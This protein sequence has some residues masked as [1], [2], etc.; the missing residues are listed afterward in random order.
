MLKSSFYITYAFLMTTGTITFIEALRTKDPHVRNILNLETCIS[1]VAAFFYG[2]FISELYES[3]DSEKK[4]LTTE[5]H[6]KLVKTRYV[7]WSITTPIMLLVLLMVLVRNDATQLVPLGKFITV[8]VLNYIMLGVGFLGESGK[9][10]LG[11]SNIIGFGAFASMF[12]YIY[13]NFVKPQFDDKLVFWMFAVV[14]TFYGVAQMM[15]PLSRN[16][17]YN[18]LD[19]IA[20]CFV[21]I[22]LWAYFTNVF[23]V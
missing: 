21:G 8:L 16:L 9:I 11:T 18:V 17:A 23:C 7:D 6:E 20:K 10:A 12:T 22:F 19:L 3:D 5:D 13:R 1:I 14:W 2:N 15:D 4:E